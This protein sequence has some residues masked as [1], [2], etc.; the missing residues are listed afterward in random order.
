MHGC[1]EAL[2]KISVTIAL[3]MTA[4]EVQFE[5]ELEVCRSTVVFEAPG[6]AEKES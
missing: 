6:N 2:T 3:L 5:Q 1:Q 4:L